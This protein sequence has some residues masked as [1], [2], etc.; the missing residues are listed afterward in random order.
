MHLRDRILQHLRPLG[1]HLRHFFGTNTSTVTAHL[2]ETHL[3]RPLKLV[4]SMSLSLALAA[5]AF[6]QTR[7]ALI[8]EPAPTTQPF[9]PTLMPRQIDGGYAVVVS[10]A[11]LADAGWAKV[12]DALKQKYGRQARVFVWDASVDEVKAG[13]SE[14]LPRYTCFVATPKEA[15]RPFVNTIH[16]L[17]RNLNDDPYPDTIWGILTGLRS[18][19]ALRIAQTSEPLEIHNVVSTTGVH[20]E[21][22][23]S[24]YTISDGKQGSI[25]QKG[26]AAKSIATPGKD[27]PDRAHEVVEA[28]H[29]VKPDLLVTS[30]HAGERVLEMPF[31]H[32]VL[33]GRNGQVV[34]VSTSGNHQAMHLGDH[35][36]ELASPNPKVWLAA[37]NC[38]IGHIDG[39][40]S[41]NNSMALAMMHSAGV[42]QMVGY[43]V[44]TW[45][46][47]GGW[48]TL[49]WFQNQP[50]RFTMAE[51]FFIND[52]DITRRLAK[53][54]PGRE[55]YAVKVYND[56]DLDALAREM[57]E[58]FPKDPKKQEDL[59]GLTWDHDVVAFYGDPAWSAKVAA[60]PCDFDQQIHADTTGE[61]F[62]VTAN[63]NGEVKAFTFLPKKIHAA[64][65]KATGDAKDVL[66]TDSYVLADFGKMKALEKKTVVISAK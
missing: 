29:A 34:G 57:G 14:M 16:R 61:T 46:G 53:N 50:G 47:A 30:A 38:L 52:A 6:G 48:G 63:A 19:D 40:N 26:D 58:P 36:W 65:F 11:T 22:Y 54:Y 56:E 4:G 21:F 64:D 60:H 43:T 62:E 13:L 28:V 35:G 5:S 9:V 25:F 20:G 17:T 1:M 44:T 3:T 66:L 33:V 39:N 8:V 18:A 2:S 51:S 41:P 24:V 45:Y 37:G 12:V 59:I 32:G 10:K 15:G 55:R 42:T 7:P 49:N 27:D 23:D 31:S